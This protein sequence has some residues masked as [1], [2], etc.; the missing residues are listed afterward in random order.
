VEPAVE[1]R[2]VIPLAVSDC[3]A[4]GIAGVAKG[5]DILVDLSE[6]GGEGGVGVS[7]KDDFAGGVS[8]V[9]EEAVVVVGDNS[10]RG[11]ADSDIGWMVKCFSRG[12]S[13]SVAFCSF[14]LVMSASIL[15]S[16]NSSRSLCASIL[17]ASLS[18]S[19]ARI[20]SSSMTLRSIVWLYFCSMSSSEDSVFRCFRS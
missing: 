12:A 20:S 10:E 5:L 8:K 9:G 14:S 2:E 6:N 1:G 18:C 7:D 13:C 11:D 19:P 17:S 3:L 16:D 15:R 4:L